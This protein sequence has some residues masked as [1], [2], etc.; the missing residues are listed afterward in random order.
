MRYLALAC[1]YDGTLAGDGVVSE[2]T[3]GALRRLLASGRRLILVTGRE[4]DQLVEAFPHIDLFERVVA[5][6]GGLLYRPG[7]RERKVLSDPPPEQFVQALAEQA[8]PISVGQAIVATWHPNETIVLETIRQLGLEL[9]VIFN[10]GAVMVL[11]QGVNKATGL[12]VALEEMG[13]S[14]HNAVGVGDAENDHSFLGVC[15]CSVAVAN[16]VSSLKQEADLVTWGE[17]GAGVQELID[18]LIT[19]DLQGLEPQLSR[20][21]ILLGDR[22][23][24][25]QVHLEPYGQSL[26]LAGSSGAGKSTIATGILERLA[27]AG[28]QFCLVDPEGDYAD[29]PKMV[30]LGDA[31]KPPSIDEIMQLLEKPAENVIVNLLGLGVDD[32]PPFFE[33]LL[34]RLQELRARAGRPH[35]LVVDEAH[36]LMPSSW[37]AAALTVPQALKEL[38]LITVHPQSVSSAVLTGI[39]TAIAVGES[40][41]ATL[42][43]FAQTSEAPFIDAAEVDLEPG[44]A[45]VWNVDG[46]SPPFSVSFAPSQTQRRRHHRKYAKGELGRDKSF[47]FRGPE[48]KLN[49]RASNLHLFMQIADGVDEQTWLHH[50]EAGDYSRWFREAIKDDALAHEVA[51]IEGT[52][53]ISATESRRRI[54]RAIGERYTAPA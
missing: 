36:H 7:S 41:V 8:V 39:S 43:S 53:N 45:L 27:E 3:V 31:D 33:A 16:A 26:L 49:L 35:W 37:A 2:A 11:P 24:G 40:P 22:S 54:T 29:F 14:P 44:Q 34:P 52:R 18:G 17:R 48:E 21:R 23:T 25:Q 19:A 20:H 15:E 30:S 50:L 9:Q 42:R 51:E 46:G 10:K 13:L 28:Y 4:L 47:Y 5:E 38:M 32:R 1:D 6:N 12:R